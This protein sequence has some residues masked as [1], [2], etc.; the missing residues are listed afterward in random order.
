MLSF[1]KPLLIIILI[2]Q[3]ISPGQSEAENSINASGISLVIAHIVLLKILTLLRGF[4]DKLKL[5]ANFS[6]RKPNQYRK[7]TR[8]PRSH[9]RI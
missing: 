3:K 8:T 1:R 5:I 2:G 4:G 9:I 7:M 6:P